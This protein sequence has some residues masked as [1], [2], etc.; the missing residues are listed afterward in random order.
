M[1]DDS[2]LVAIE[3]FGREMDERRI[4][5]TAVINHRRDELFGAIDYLSTSI[6]DLDNLIAERKYDHER[7]YEM[8]KTM[9][10]RVTTCKKVYA[11]DSTLP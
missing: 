2:E 8:L 7:A 5:R 3:Q 6:P 9:I 10:E 4:A 1:N 11:D